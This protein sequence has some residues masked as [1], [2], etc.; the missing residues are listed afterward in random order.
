MARRL[1][2]SQWSCPWDSHRRV[3]TLAR[4][5]RYQR[6]QGER[7]DVAVGAYRWGTRWTILS[8]PAVIKI[9]LRTPEKDI[10]TV[11]SL[12]VISPVDPRKPVTAPPIS[13]QTQFSR[14]PYLSPS[15]TPFGRADVAR[16]ERGRGDRAA[17]QRCAGGAH[18]RLAVI[19][20]GLQ[21]DLSRF[22]AAGK[23][24]MPASTIK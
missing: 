13:K 9:R 12:M 17:P 22:R 18:W 14:Y 3:P 16:H 8:V 24:S 7:D 19:A 11:Y 15:P 20:P 1:S 6:P 4:A 21:P 5:C 10:V 23:Y 2:G